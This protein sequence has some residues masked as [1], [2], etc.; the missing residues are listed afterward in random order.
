M[1]TLKAQEKPVEIE[2]SYNPNPKQR[3]FHGSAAKY[4][5]F[6]GGWGNGKTDAGCAEAFALAM[7]YP[8]SVG[9]IARKTRPE[10]RA[11]TQKQFFNGS[12]GPPGSWPGVPQ[13]VIR[14]FNK[15]DNEL[16]LINDTV[17][18][19]WPLDDPTK[20]TN[21]NL[22]WYLIDQAEETTEEIFMML[23][24]RLRQNN[25]PRCGLLL[26]NPNGH[27][28]IWRRNVFLKGGGAY[29]DH[30]MVH[31]KTTDNPNL[32][33]DYITSLMNMPES[34]RNRFMEGSFDVFSGQIWP[35]F[36][37]DVHTVRPFPVPDNWDIIEGIDHG[38]RNPTAVLWAAFD[39]VGNCF[40]I[41]EHYE[42]GK[43]V[44]HHARAIHEK[45]AYYRLPIYT[46]ID[47]SASHQDPNTGRSVIDEYWDHGIVTI[48]SD[49][50]VPARINRV[51]EWLMLNKEWPHPLTGQVREEGCP[52]LYIFKNCVQL[53]EHVQQY[54]WKKKPPMKEEDAKEQP[55]EKDDHDVDALG[56]ILM[57]RPHPAAPR[58]RP[59]DEMTPAAQYW[60]RVRDR[61]DRAGGR[62]GHSLLGSEA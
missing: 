24:G 51:A 32:P 2:I 12:G 6:V 44:G 45:R 52:K 50:H 9:L 46:V 16:T 35:E 15:T 48:P 56:Y 43:L 54:Q 8:G 62:G 21:L 22:G 19:F 55:L 30:H 31:A 53:I 18:H 36:D 37:A 26:A 5:F 34:W 25:S 10:L 28:W 23:E 49:R 29:K 57:T 17:V 41:D 33:A 40:I 38:R 61:M 13:E 7:E 58:A 27:D 1:T 60:R 14:K 42:A 39:E 20:L 3:E 47:A 11:T 59:E 4:R